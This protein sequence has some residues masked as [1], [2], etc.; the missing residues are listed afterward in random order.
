MGYGVGS[1]LSVVVSIFA[2]LVGLDRDRAFYATVVIVV[3][4]YYVLF[5]VMGGTTH[6]LLVEL[7]VM[8]GF[9]VVAVVGFKRNL[10]WVAAALVGHGVFDIFHGGLVDNAGVPEYWP[11]FCMSYD[12]G[13]GGILAWL[14]YRAKIAARKDA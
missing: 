3:A 5:A 14:L 9:V 13:A 8:A 10:W 2:R 12:I 4:S 11:A 6:A 1:L 7:G